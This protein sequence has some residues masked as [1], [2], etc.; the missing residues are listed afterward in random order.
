MGVC[1]Y[2]KQKIWDEIGEVDHERDKMLFELEQEC[3]DAY[4]RKVEQASHGRAQL[5]QAVAEAE[6]QLA[7]MY[8]AL[9]DGPAHIKKVDI[10]NIREM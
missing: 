9:G 4:R 1:D 7:D 5:R 10:E 6:S 8:A 2:W 3:L